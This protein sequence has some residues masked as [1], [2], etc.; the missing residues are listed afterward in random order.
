ML[1]CLR[2]PSPGPASRG[3]PL[4]R[5]EGRNH[6]AK[7]PSPSEGVKKSGRTGLAHTFR[8]AFS[9]VSRI[10]A[11]LKVC[12]SRFFHSFSGRGG[13]AKRW[14]R[15]AGFFSSLLKGVLLAV[16]ALPTLAAQQRVL[17][18]VDARAT[19]GPFPSAW[20]FFGYDEP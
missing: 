17:I 6:Q 16:L 7:Q 3:H 2:V 9:G 11:D 20:S 15:V 18:R 1:T 10:F 8:C 12:V 4:P 13:T 14:V 5:G 19:Q